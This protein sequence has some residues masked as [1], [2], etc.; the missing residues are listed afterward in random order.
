MLTKMYFCEQTLRQGDST[1][2]GTIV[3]VR[4]EHFM[5]HE[6]LDW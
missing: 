1:V 6:E 2:A 4:L 3:R 5:C